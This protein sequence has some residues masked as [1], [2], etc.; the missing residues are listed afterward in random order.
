[1]PTYPH[2]PQR[3]RKVAKEKEIYYYLIRLIFPLEKTGKK[4]TVL[5]KTILAEYDIHVPL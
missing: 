3:K 2:C 1:L 4:K 5:D